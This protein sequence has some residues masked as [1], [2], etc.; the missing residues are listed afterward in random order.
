MFRLQVKNKCEEPDADGWSP[1]HLS[2]SV[3]RPLVAGLQSSSDLSQRS[4]SLASGGHTWLSPLSLVTY[5]HQ[6]HTRLT[7]LITS[8]PPP[9]LAL[10]V[11]HHGDVVVPLALHVVYPLPGRHVGQEGSLAWGQSLM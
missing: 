4:S 3:S 10:D 7:G 8:P 1:P 9:D 11:L 2:V 6:R 5:L